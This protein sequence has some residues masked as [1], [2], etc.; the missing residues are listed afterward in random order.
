MVRHV[1]R[2]KRRQRA[3]AGGEGCGSEGV[4]RKGAGKQ[5]S[6]RTVKTKKAASDER[7]DGFSSSSLPHIMVFA[8]AVVASA[9]LFSC[10]ELR[11]QERRSA[12]RS[13]S[14]FVDSTSTRGD[15]KSET[16]ARRAARLHPELR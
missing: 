6:R 12:E 3:G 5:K 13:Q 7:R 16:T 14:S 2:C 4:R 9:P 10:L 11:A 15:E 1:V 8:A